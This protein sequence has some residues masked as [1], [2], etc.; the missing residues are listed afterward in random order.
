[1]VSVLKWVKVTDP[2]PPY[3]IV[4]P[5]CL[6]RHAKLPL[7]LSPD[8]SSAAMMKK[9]T[10]MDSAAAPPPNNALIRTI[11]WD[12][13]DKSKF[14]PMSMASSFTVRTFLYPLTLIRTRLQ[15]QYKND[16]YNGTYDAFKKIFRSEGETFLVNI[17]LF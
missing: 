17:F 9:I 1:M 4:S 10:T 6:D 15:V 3:P 2:P 5:A 11:E 12:M 7:L 13:L 16:V 8:P 14:I